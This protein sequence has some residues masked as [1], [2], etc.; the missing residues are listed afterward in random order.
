MKF[1]LATNFD[2]K[3]IHFVKKY[4]SGGAITSVFGKL[5]S[6]VL[7]G[8]RNA[9]SLPSVSIKELRDHVLLCHENGL[10]FNYLLNPLCLD[11][12]EVSVHGHRKLIRFIGHLA[13]LGVDGVTINSPYLCNL[14]R[15]QFPDFE[16]TIGYHSGIGS[17]QQ[18][19]YWEE[20]G[21]DVLTLVHSVNRNFPLLE[22]LLSY[23]KQTGT[24]LRLIANNV[25]LRDCPYKLSHGT[26]NAHASQSG[27]ASSGFF[28]DYNLLSCTYRKI[29][30]PANLIAS[31][32]IRPEDLHFYEAL[33]E[34]T[35][36]V[37]LSIKLLE[38]T[39]KTSFLTR[40]VQ[41]YMDRSY[42]GNLLEI[43]AWPDYQGTDFKILTA[44]WNAMKGGYNLKEIGR[45][46]G[47]FRIPPI[48]VENKKLDGFLDKF[49]Q[50]EECSRKICKVDD[51]LTDSGNHAGMASVGCGYC[52]RWAEQAVRF[53]ENEVNAWLEQAEESL[54]IVH[55]SRLFYFNKS[56]MS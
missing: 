25:C 14:I 55:E 7:G 41:A 29:A 12:R 51:C 48:V 11:N 18:I 44:V 34:K 46:M 3:L 1:D 56:R 53:N 24:R 4:N 27:H 36:N 8:G 26:S 45:F 19:R 37:N 5:R 32:W 50:H 20:L 31:E 38:R 15:K 13:D 16:I 43:M 49:A 23:T 10:K 35:G 2:P 54:E 9:P 22:S 30:N 52:K 40:V 47:F 17:L 6:D 28:I 39:K 33:C 21:A 42:E